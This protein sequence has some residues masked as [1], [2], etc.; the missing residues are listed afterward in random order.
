MVASMSNNQSTAA[1]T[2]KSN[3]DVEAVVHASNQFAFDLYRKLSAEKGN[4]FFSPGSISTALDMVY[5]GAKGDT[6]EQMAQVLAI[7][8]KLE[9]DTLPEAAGELIRQ[10]NAGGQQGSYQLAVANRLWGQQGFKFLDPFL[11]LVGKYYG[12]DL[13]KVDFAKAEAARKTINTWVEKATNDKIKDLIPQG[14]VNSM[15]CLVLTNAV[16]FKGTWKDSFD[17]S[18]TRPMP[19]SLSGQRTGRHADDVSE[20]AS[21]LRRNST[22]GQP[23]AEDPATAVQDCR[24]REQG[25]VHGAAA[26]GRRYGT[27]QLRTTIDLGQ[28]VTMDDQTS[29]G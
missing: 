6:A 24:D 26:A 16:Y 12:A 10:L 27:K 2:S 3:P 18:A 9:G 8:G 11:N 29:I 23:R 15:T 1:D 4:L 28:L 25:T 5:A 20:E 19:F 22:A 14:A 21:Q 17:Q 13:E 7:N